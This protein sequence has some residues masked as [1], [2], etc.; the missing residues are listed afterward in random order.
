[1]LRPVVEAHRWSR[2]DCVWATFVHLEGSGSLAEHQ[3][4]SN[5]SVHS[6]QP[7]TDGSTKE[8][9]NSFSARASER[10]WKQ[11]EYKL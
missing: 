8:P 7:R 10:S 9:E 6:L 11:A 1:M 4:E 5:D 3:L 2:E